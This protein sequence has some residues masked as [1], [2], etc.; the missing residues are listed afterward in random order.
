M[1]VYVCPLLWPGMLPLISGSR[2]INCELS[3][4]ETV[5]FCVLPLDLDII[6][7]GEL[8]YLFLRV[9][10]GEMGVHPLVGDAAPFL[11]T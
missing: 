1:E 6:S 2:T 10:V 5:P 9:L 8:A 3:I 4:A 7:G 11:E